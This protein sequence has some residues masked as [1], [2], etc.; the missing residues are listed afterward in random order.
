M[1]RTIRL[2]VV[3]GAV[4]LTGLAWPSTADAQR[5][6]PAG[7]VSR[8]SASVPRG[9]GSHVAVPR[10]Y[11]PYGHP[12][13]RSY[14][15]PYYGYGSY[16][17]P[18]YYPY[19]RPYYYSS[20]YYP[21]YSPWS[22]SFGFGFGTYWGSA[23]YYAYPPYP[24]PYSYSYPYP[25]PSAYP[26]SYP[27]PSP[28]YESPTAGNRVQTAPPASRSGDF[29][30]LSLRVVPGDAAILIDREEWD[31][32]QGDD[33]FSIE[34]PAGQH[35]VEIRKQGYG[36]YVRTIDVPA[37]RTIVLNIGLTAGGSSQLTRTPAGPSQVARTVPL[38]N[39]R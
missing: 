24:Y 31:R 14:Y 1:T 18:Y 30:T 27:P 28:G 20:Y 38:R 13:Y 12:Y 19:Y 26:N 15:R 21:Y 4:A 34:L 29:G 3:L 23:P 10:T 8:G 5:R 25:Y 39:Y 11:A 9:G 22:F 17:R 7:A 35:Q 32:P 6:P 36:S 33:R 37:G 16:Y 2:V